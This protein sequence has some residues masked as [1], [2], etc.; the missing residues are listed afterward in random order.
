MSE[1]SKKVKHE[2]WNILS[3]KEYTILIDESQS[4][5]MKKQGKMAYVAVVIPSGIELP[6]PIGEH[7][8]EDYSKLLELHGEAKAGEILKIDLDALAHSLCGVLG[9]TASF[10]Y[11]KNED[12]RCSA[13]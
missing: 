10:P 3:S 11:L 4:M 5:A 7:V 1:P 13:E 12:D 9:I 2:I 6:A 8:V